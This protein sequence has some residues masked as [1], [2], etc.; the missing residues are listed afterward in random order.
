MGSSCNEGLPFFIGAPNA[1]GIGAASFASFSGK[2]IWEQ[3]R[4]LGQVR[5]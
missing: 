3:G 1:L 2:G 5:E 4:E